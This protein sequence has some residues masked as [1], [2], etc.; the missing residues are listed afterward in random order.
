MHLRCRET[1]W[2]ILSFAGWRCHWPISVGVEHHLRL[3][4][5]I[6]LVAKPGWAPGRR[7]DGACSRIRT[8]V[9]SLHPMGLS[10]YTQH[11]VL[12]L[13]NLKSDME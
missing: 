2:P 9:Y 12:R 3:A 10:S 13:S 7:L 8:Y 1:L 6:V 11:P 5:A 4:A